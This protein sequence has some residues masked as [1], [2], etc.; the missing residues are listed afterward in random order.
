VLYQHL[1]AM[2]NERSYHVTSLAKIITQFY[3]IY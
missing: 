1:A 3:D 2:V